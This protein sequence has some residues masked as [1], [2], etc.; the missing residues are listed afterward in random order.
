MTIASA[1][2]E[3]APAPRPAPTPGR[4]W[5]IVLRA[6]ELGIL[7]VIF[8]VFGGTTIYNSSFASSASV[9][10]LLAGASIYALLGVGETIVIITRNVDLSVGSVLGLSAYVVGEVFLHNPNFPVPLA[11]LVGIG[12]GVVCG[13]VNGAIVAVARVPSLVVTLGTLY[14]IRGVD[15]LVVNGVQIDPS[16]IPGGFIGVGV[17]NIL[18]VPWIFVITAVV[19][20]VV[21]YAMR[22]FRSNRD[23]YAIGS[24]PAAAE[25]AG[26]PVRKRVFW[27]FVFSGAIAGL[28]GALWL[29]QFATVASTA[30]SGYELI[31]V[32]GVVVGGVAIFGG[33]G[34][35]LGAA[36]GP[37][38]LNTINQ[39]LV[40]AR[41]SAFW[42]QAIAG[43]LLIAA[44]AFD[45]FVS[46][47]RERNLRLRRAARGA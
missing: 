42:N 35:V 32:S 45:R 16:S 22:T 12:V 2:G 28:G 5:D 33:S 38:L 36:L 31:V 43:G 4:V 7:V 26:V 18:G 6:R 40:A 34:T 41:I 11:F 27:A 15:A 30:G 24:N 37:L 20:L 47:R 8:A 46:L 10:Q 25:L 17:N 1:V 29:A 39:A 9:Q 13:V 21:G 3:L 23:L 14:L 44:I 19:V